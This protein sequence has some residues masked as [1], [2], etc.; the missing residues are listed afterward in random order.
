MNVRPLLRAACVTTGLLIL[1]PL[2]A[3]AQQGQAPASLGMGNV[4]C[5]DYLRAARSSDILYH[6]ASQWLLGYV[7]GINGALKTMNGAEAPLALTNDQTLRSAASYCEAN[8]T[9]TLAAAATQWYASLPKAEPQAVEAKSES[10][11][12][13]SL[14]LNLDSAP[15]RK[16]LLDRR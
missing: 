3:H 10:K 8:P 7:S 6:Q 12:S 1:A 2:P 5:R 16:P 13:G 11:S 15:A 4:V 14:I 9:T